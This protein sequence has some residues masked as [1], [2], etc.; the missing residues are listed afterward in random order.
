MLGTFQNSAPETVTLTCS[1]STIGP[2]GRHYPFEKKKKLF[3][4][5][6]RREPTV[7]DKPKTINVV[8]RLG[9]LKIFSPRHSRRLRANRSF[10]R[11]FQ[12]PPPHTRFETINTNSKIVKFLSAVSMK[13]ND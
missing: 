9:I 11:L 5:F 1:K 10:N 7:F 12:T 4:L 3:L 6:N 8:V 2:K 13:Q